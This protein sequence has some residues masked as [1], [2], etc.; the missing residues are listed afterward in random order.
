MDCRTAADWIAAD[1]RAIGIEHVEV[2][3]T[4]GHPIVYGDWLSDSQYA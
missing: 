1:L 4:E 2:I 3:E